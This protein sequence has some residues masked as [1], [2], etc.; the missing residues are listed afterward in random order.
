MEEVA[1]LGARSRLEVGAGA[2]H[3]EQRQVVVLVDLGVELGPRLGSAAPARRVGERPA[4]LAAAQRLLDDLAVA[5]GRVDL[6][7][8]G[9]R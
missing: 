8:R 2:L 4:Q 1:A 9:R 7:A 5:L 3:G 6:R